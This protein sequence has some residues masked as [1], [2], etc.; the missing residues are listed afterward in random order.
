[1][2]RATKR[3]VSVTVQF[4]KATS[5]GALA[6]ADVASIKAQVQRVYKE[7]DYVGSLMTQGLHA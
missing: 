7:A 1:M 6:S 4:Y 5:N 2:Q 3:K